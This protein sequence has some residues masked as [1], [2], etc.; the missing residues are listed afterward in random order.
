MTRMEVASAMQH[1]CRVV[2]QGLTGP[3]AGFLASLEVYD[4]D[5]GYSQVCMLCNECLI[6]FH[7]IIE[8]LPLNSLVYLAGGPALK[9]EFN[10]KV[11]VI[12]DLKLHSSVQSLPLTHTGPW[13]VV[14]GDISDTARFSNTTPSFIAS[15]PLDLPHT[16]GHLKYSATFDADGGDGIDGIAICVSWYGSDDDVWEDSLIIT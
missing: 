14:S 11:T 12:D 4:I 5:L 7:V 15:L 1:S 2:C 16:V 13:N 9:V 8:G 3:M 6:E 10:A